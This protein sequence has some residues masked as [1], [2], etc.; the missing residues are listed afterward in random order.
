M[1]SPLIISNLV[2]MSAC[3]PDRERS[4]N[5]MSALAIACSVPLGSELVPS[6]GNLYLVLEGASALVVSVP[7]SVDSGYIWAAM[8][9]VAWLIKRS[10]NHKICGLSLC[11]NN[12][13][14]ERPKEAVS[15]TLVQRTKDALLALERE[16]RWLQV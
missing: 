1:P 12:S 2:Q 11:W 10:L 8:I 5:D 6:E 3:S 14:R 4:E 16:T 15:S 7:C 13:Q 9:R